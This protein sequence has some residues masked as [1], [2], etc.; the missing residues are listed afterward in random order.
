MS[1]DDIETIIFKFQEKLSEK[2]C[3]YGRQNRMRIM[4]VED[5]MNGIGKKVGNLYNLG[6]AILLTMIGTLCTLV[7]MLITK[8]L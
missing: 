7:G 3:E 6:W 4:G 5:D 8:K 2:G 1:N